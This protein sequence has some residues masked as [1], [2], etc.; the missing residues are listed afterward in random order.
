MKKIKLSALLLSLALLLTSLCVSANATGGYNWFIKRCGTSQPKIPAEL[1]DK[2]NGDCYYIDR[3]VNEKSDDKV[4]YLTFDVGYENGNVEK[5]L[6]IMKSEAVSGAFFILDHVIL[7]NTDLVKRMADEGHLVCN[8]TKNHKDMTTVSRE[9]MIKNLTDLE[10]IYE[11]KTGYTLSKYFRFPEGRFNAET[12]GYASELGYKSVFWSLAYADWDND[13]QPDAEKSVKL[14]L[15][16]T[17]NGAVI[18]LH[19]T[20]STNVEILPKL[21][22]CWRDMGYRFGTLDEL[23]Q[24]SS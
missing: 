17:H 18:L 8:H 10:K 9:E 15:D 2:L 11:E 6:D 1:S 20:S 12:V 7:K 14:L 4:I 5:I 19:P 13:R 23:T 24:K 22:K 3:S 16:N 21:I